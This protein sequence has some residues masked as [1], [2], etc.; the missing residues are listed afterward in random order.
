[1]VRELVH[2]DVH[3]RQLEPHPRQHVVPRR[4]SART[5][6]TRSGTC[7]TSRST[8]P[9]ASRPPRSRRS[10][11]LLAGTAAGR[12]GADAGRERRDRRGARRV[13][14]PLSRCRGCSALVLVFTG[15]GPGVGLPRAV[16]RRINSSRRNFGLFSAGDEDG[17]TAFFAH[18]GGFVFGVIVATA[19][20]RSGQRQD[21]RALEAV[22]GRAMAGSPLRGT[23]VTLRGDDLP[24]AGGYLGGSGASAR[25]AKR[26]GSTSTSR[27]VMRLP[28]SCSTRSRAPFTRISSPSR[29]PQAQSSS[30]T[31]PGRVRALR[32]GRRGALGLV[33]VVDGHR[34]R[35]ILAG[36]GVDAARVASWGRWELGL[37]LADD[38][39]QDVLERDDAGGPRTARGPAVTASC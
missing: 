14:G 24:L 1:M 5:S 13:L 11:T 18:V 23:R 20:A 21:R 36:A 6:R 10:M 16:V 22:S 32:W 37:D 9:A 15:A 4:S 34:S 12:A 19:M 3:A 38:L 25:R 7:G 17:G 26:S 30:N 33:E 39:L 28:S 2:R 8:S 35:R 31:R 29:G 27:R